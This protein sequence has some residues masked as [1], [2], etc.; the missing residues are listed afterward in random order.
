MLGRAVRRHNASCSHSSS[1]KE[2]RDLD[3]SDFLNVHTPQMD[4][5]HYPNWCDEKRLAIY[6]AINLKRT[7]QQKMR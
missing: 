5:Y 2:Q 4:T 6:Q 7:S 3:R 1:E